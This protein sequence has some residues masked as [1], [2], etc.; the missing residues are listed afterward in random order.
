MATAA[1]HRLLER[2]A[3]LKNAPEDVREV[4]YGAPSRVAILNI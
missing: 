2:Q 3:F 1:T 4:Y